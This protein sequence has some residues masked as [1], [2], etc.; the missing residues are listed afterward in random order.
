LWFFG[1]VPFLYVPAFTVSENITHGWAEDSK[2]LFAQAVHGAICW[3][4]SYH[5]KIVSYIIAIIKNYRLGFLG[6]FFGLRRSIVG[7]TTVNP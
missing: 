5:M 2:T 3:I 4:L 1:F 7:I 6:T